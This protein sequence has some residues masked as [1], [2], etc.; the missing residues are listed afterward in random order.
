M[1]FVDI[2]DK[3]GDKKDINCQKR[4]LTDNT[5]VFLMAGS[6]LLIDHDHSGIKALVI[7][8]T[9]SEKVV[10]SRC[11]ILFKD[12][13]EHS[14]TAGFTEAG[15]FKA[16]MDSMAE[17]MDF[18]SCSS[19]VVLV[20]PA[21]VHFRIVSLP[22]RSEK[23]IQQILPFELEP[24]LPI[25]NEIY[26]SDFHLLD[27]QGDQNIIF[28]AS[29]SEARIETYF[30][31]LGS[32]GIRPKM[33]STAGCALAAAFLREHPH[34]TDTAF[35]YIIEEKIT[36][37]LIN[38]RKPWAVRTLPG[39]FRSAE[40][41]S[42]GLRQTITGFRQRTGEDRSFDLVIGLD[43]DMTGIGGF[44][45]TLQ[46]L[47]V[48]FNPTAQ[49][50]QR[51]QTI[52]AN[53]LLMA[54]SPDNA[55]N[56]PVNFCKGKYSSTS[57]LKIH[58]YSIAASIVLFFCMI[59]FSLFNA[60]LDNS[61]LY[62]QI[63]LIDEKAMS[64]FMKTFPE[65]KR[66]QDPYLQMKANVKDILK[67]TDAGSDDNQTAGKEVKAVAV[68]TEISVKIAPAIDVEISSFLLSA[69]RL[70]LSGSTDNFNNVDK[71][72]TGLEPSELLKKVEISSAATDRKGDRV[73]F[74]FNIDL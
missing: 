37:V 11:N 28:T 74:K 4:S 5:R 22:F 44:L 29:I 57:F 52:D 24:L 19:A 51:I 25:S 21:F 3:I 60:G 63:S 71:I 20:S 12:L 23:K 43:H 36:L 50:D 62:K 56:D 69:G 18:Q 15:L 17:K 6:Y 14:E 41:L 64:I 54:V 68:L 10:K 40:A 9:D 42:A 70:V 16:A 72:K 27:R 38:N 31:T 48:S 45:D 47:Q 73:N 35:L 7:D 32:F 8:E 65:Q 61:K 30:Q 67:K 58:F 34:V 46:N 53:K 39:S 66:I 2:L 49:K 59:G 13:P 1:V 55:G 26:I 33:I